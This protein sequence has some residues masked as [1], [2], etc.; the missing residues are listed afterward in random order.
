MSAHALLNSVARARFP[1][2]DFHTHVSL[3]SPGRGERASAGGT[4]E[5][6]GCG[7]N[8]HTMVNLTGGCGEDFVGDDRQLRPRVSKNVCSMTEPA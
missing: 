4:G 5:D 2:I 3:R 6:D 7:L 1:V 8:R